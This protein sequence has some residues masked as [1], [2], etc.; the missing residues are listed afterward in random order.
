MA[1]FL[2]KNAQMYHLTSYLAF[3]DV[4][5]VYSESKIL[6]NKVL[7]TS[8]DIKNKDSGSARCSNAMILNLGIRNLC[9]PT[10]SDKRGQRFDFGHGST[11]YFHKEDISG[12]I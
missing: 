6:S 5:L 1:G 2:K 4:N 9:V 7:T 8:K 11:S 12:K 3:P 10:T